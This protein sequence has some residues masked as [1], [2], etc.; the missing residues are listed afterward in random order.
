[1]MTNKVISILYDT[2]ETTLQHVKI[3][4]A[5]IVQKLS[6]WR[7]LEKLHMNIEEEKEKEATVGFVA[8]SQVLMSDGTTKPIEEISVG[9]IVTSY[10]GIS[11]C[12]LTIDNLRSR[13]KP[14]ALSSRR[15]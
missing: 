15:C 2:I 9:D 1:M 13:W 12:M 4:C 3:D 8:G 14:C 5:A 11:F 7:K 10:N 6:K